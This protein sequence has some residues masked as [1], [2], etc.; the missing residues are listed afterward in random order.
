MKNVVLL[1][2]ITMF[3][4]LVLSGCEKDDSFSEELLTENEQTLKL[5]APSGEYIASNVRMLKS[6]LAPIIE[7]SFGESKDFEIILISFDSL[8]VGFSA[9]IEYKTLDGFESNV[10]IRKGSAKRLKT[11]AESDSEVEGYSYACK[12]NK[13]GRC[14]KCRL[15]NDKKNEQIRCACDEGIVEGCSLYEYSW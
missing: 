4:V 7:Y 1:L 10:I 15:V 6:K 9:E 2:N 12:R 5:K 3:M 8:A 13:S 11:R 14:K